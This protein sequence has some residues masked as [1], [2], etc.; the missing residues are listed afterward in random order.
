M[1]SKANTQSNAQPDLDWSQVKE[2]VLLLN[3]AVAQLKNSMSEGDESVGSLAQSLTFV[4]GKM[5]VIE[6]AAQDLDDCPI[7]QTILGNW[8]EVNAKVQSIIVAFQFYDKLTQRLGHLSYSLAGLGELVG[9]R[10]RLYSPYEWHGLQDLIK[11]KYT[12]DSDKKMLDA[13]VNGSTVEEAL[14]LA[15]DDANDKKDEIELF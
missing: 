6:S 14:E 1:S 9:D 13:I 2:T 11:S 15:K 12:L 3:L 8:T 4:M 10:D 7:K 5:R